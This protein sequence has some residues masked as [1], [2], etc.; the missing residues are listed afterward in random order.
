MVSAMEAYFR[1]AVADTF[2]S[3]GGT[4]LVVAVI[5]I[6]PVGLAL[7]AWLGGVQ[8]MMP[9]LQVWLIYG[10]A[11]TGLVFFT[12]FLWNLAC[13]PYRIERDNRI[14]AETEVSRL[15]DILGDGAGNYTISEAQQDQLSALLSGVDFSGESLN[16]LYN[17]SFAASLDLADK[18]VD[19]VRGANI[20]TAVT[21]GA[22][23][24]H[25]PKDRGIFV[26]HGSAETHSNMGQAVKSALED[27]GL[28]PKTRILS[29]NPTNA[30][31]IYVARPPKS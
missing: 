2:H 14:D 4:G 21:T 23:F 22:F 13:A 18:I 3:L 6:P 17:P 31:F 29:D 11:A 16:V 30:P 20:T 28:I 1:R 24:D 27:I 8:A 5:A 15:H 26:Y 7:H 12:V 9:E 25:D 10:L 19:A